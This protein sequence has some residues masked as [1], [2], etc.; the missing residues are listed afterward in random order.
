[1][2]NKKLKLLSLLFSLIMLTSILSGC[3]F[4]DTIIKDLTDL[5][6]DVLP[7]EYPQVL[8]SDEMS[9]HFMMLGNDKAGDCV[10]IKAGETDILIDAGSRLNSVKSIQAYIN[11]YMTDNVLEYV[12]VTH[13]DQ[14]HID[15]FVR[16][17]SQQS[18][19]DLYECQTIIDFNLSNK[20]LLTEKGNPT[21]L[22]KY[23]SS[24]DE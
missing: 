14:D 20:S 11:K 7:S 6:D 19:F 15:G 3:Q 24:R 12:I 5:P 9:F 22:S 10:Y 23:Y 18:I 8:E 13:S 4:L 17:S 1:M 2:K 16:T 21:L